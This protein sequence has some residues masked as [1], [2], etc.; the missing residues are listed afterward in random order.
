[1][2]WTEQADTMMKAWTEAQKQM[3]SGW[4]DL[5]Q[6]SSGGQRGLGPMDPSYWLRQGMEAWT[7]ARPP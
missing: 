4:Y 1:M 5:A 6:S 3:W 7:K 2:N